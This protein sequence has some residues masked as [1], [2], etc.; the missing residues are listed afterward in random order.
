[1]TYD[2]MIRKI[3]D[4]KTAYYQTGRSELTDAEYD[5][6][7]YQATKLGYIETVGAAPVDSIDKITHEHPMLSLDK[8]HTT[9]EVI[10]F[11]GNHKVLA[12][13]KADGL[14]VSATYQDGVLTRLETRGN[15]EVGN[16]IMFHANSIL[17]LPKHINRSGRYV[18]D[19][20]CIILGHD[21]E[22]INE[23]LSK[24]ERYSHPRNLAAGSLNQLDPAVSKKRHLKFFAWDVIEGGGNSLWNNLNDA[25]MLGFDVVNVRIV[26]GSDPSSAIK[27]LKLEAENTSFQID[28]IVFKYDDISYGKSL[29]KTA[30]HFRNGIA[31]KFQDD[32]YETKL[33]SVEWQVGKTGQLTPVGIVDPVDIDGVIVEK[34][35]LH[36]I[37]IMKSLGL[38]NGCTCYVKRANDVIP[39]IDSADDDGDGVIEIPTTCQIC[40][41]KTIIRKDNESEVLYCTNDDC[42]G[43]LLGKWKTFVSKKGMDIDGLSEATLEV[44]LKRGYIDNIFANI[45]SLKDYRKELYKLDGFGKKSVDNLLAAIESSKNVDLIHFITAFSIPGIGEGQSK[46]ITK[47]YNTFEAFA[48]A[49][50]NSENFAK[51]DGIGKILNMNIHQWWVNNNYQMIDIAEIVRFKNDDFM[52]VPEGN[53]PITGM[54]F[55]ITGSLKHYKNRDELKQLIESMGGKVVGSVSKSTDYLI[56]NDVT[57]TSGKNKKANDLNI[58]IISEEEFIAMI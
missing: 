49:C 29:G 32:T 34:A 26:D 2:E 25:R 47:K 41:G 15:G 22:I 24:E 4:A 28:G 13:W 40:G 33:K 58:P 53:T 56:N 18:I 20:E 36:N 1:M 48:A 38:T 16:D 10:K 17:N 42:P 6:M 3:K 39:Q 21:F 14:T 43:K 54:S 44:L 30:H 37:S 19:G 12:M 50:E 11:A 51:I 23:K 31:F 57:S 7:V 45:Y 46:L 5:R 55:V 8:C 52:N 27:M 35:S 9:D